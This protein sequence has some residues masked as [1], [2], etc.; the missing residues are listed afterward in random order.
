M[1]ASPAVHNFLLKP[2]DRCRSPLEPLE[3]PADEKHLRKARPGRAGC[4]GQLP[5]IGF[6]HSEIYRE[7]VGLIWFNRNIT[8]VIQKKQ[9]AN[10]LT[11]INYLYHHLT[12]HNPTNYCI[13]LVI[14]EWASERW[15]WSSKWGIW[16]WW[17]TWYTSGFCFIH[18]VPYIII[19]ILIWLLL[20]L[21]HWPILIM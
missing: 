21:L 3:P 8:L 5:R 10:D 18:F 4:P 2:S 11:I 9:L 15:A 6:H 17:K 16:V 1:L 19:I 7:M 14:M 20:L 12:Q 13:I